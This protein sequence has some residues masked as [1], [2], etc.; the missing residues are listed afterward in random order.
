[1]TI[2][3]FF[4]NPNLIAETTITLPEEI[5]HQITQVLRLK[6]NDQIIVLDNTGFE[7]L[8]TLLDVNK[9]HTTAKVIEK[10]KNNN[11]PD[12]SIH[13]YM[14]LIARDN[15]E[16]TI[17][18]CVE[19]GIKEITPVITERTQFDKKVF[20]TKYDRWK[21]IIKE[22]SEQSERAI[23]P[24]LNNPI[25]FES[26]INQTKEDGTSLIASEYS[27]G[28]EKNVIPSA[29]E[30]SLDGKKV[31]I[32]IGPE[33]GF[34]EQEVAYANENNVKSLSLGKTILRAETA[35]IVSMVLLLN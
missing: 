23:L 11:E 28:E 1:M 31:N 8:V 3:R 25:N 30:E 27:R 15:F 4:I 13:L 21:K 9:K 14:A 29:V 22:A 17:Q 16:L 34:T 7:Y 2:H 5:S 20:E 24:L 33:G 32:F 35:A 26:A 6:N 19:L 10:R 18:K 12:K